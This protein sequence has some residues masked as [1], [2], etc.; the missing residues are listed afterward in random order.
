MKQGNYWPYNLDKKTE[1][2]TVP[3][4]SKPEEPRKVEEPYVTPVSPVSKVESVRDH[5][6][7]IP[8]LNPYR[9]VDDDLDWVDDWDDEKDSID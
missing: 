5:A 7:K 9:A 8:T 1:P 3:V 2:K 6:P 4:Y